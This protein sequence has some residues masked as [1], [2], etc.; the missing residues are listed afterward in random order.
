MIYNPRIKNPGGRKIEGNYYTLSIPTT[1]LDIMSLT[2]SFE[3]DGQFDLA[4]DF[5]THYEYAQSLLRPINPTLRFFTVTPGGG[6][7][8]VDNGQNLRV[9]PDLSPPPPL[10]FL[11]FLFLFSFFFPF[12][13]RFS[14]M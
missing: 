13:F 2:G 14:G 5:A 12:L 7:W 4:Y 6:N 11:S 10:F 1:L 3:Q 8:I 9:R